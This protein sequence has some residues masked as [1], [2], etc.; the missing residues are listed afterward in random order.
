MAV[1]R[2]YVLPR[3]GPN[4]SPV[5][6]ELIDD[7]STKKMFEELADLVRGVLDVFTNNGG[8]KITSASELSLFLDSLVAYFK[9]LAFIEPILPEASSAVKILPVSLQALYLY[10]SRHELLNKAGV[11]PY[12]KEGLNRLEEVFKYAG[13]IAKLYSNEKRKEFYDVIRFPADTRPGPNTSSLLIHSL[14]TSAL[15]ST[16]YINKNGV[17]E[18]LP[19]VRLAAIF[20]DIGKLLDWRRHEKISSREM[21]ELFAIYVDGYAKKAVSEASQLISNASHPL[22]RFL[23]YGDRNS[24]ELDRVVALFF[25][26]IKDSNSYNDF[27]NR[28]K[29]YAKVGPEEA[30][31]DWNFWNNYVKE[32]LMEKLTEEFCKRVSTID[33]ENPAFAEEGRIV[34]EDV[35]FVRIDVRRIQ[36]FIKVNDIW[37]MN[38]ASRLIDL[39]L[40][41]G[42][43]AYLTDVLALPIENV[44][45]FGGGNETVV[46][47]R[48][49][50][51]EN[52][53][54][55][56][57]FVEHFNREFFE[58]SPSEIVF[59]TSPFYSV[60]RLINSEID[61]ELTAKKIGYDGRHQDVNPNIYEMCDF[62]GKAPAALMSDKGERVCILCDEKRRLGDAQHFRVRS[63]FL[64]LDWSVL[65]K[66]IIEYIAGHPAEGPRPGEEYLDLSLIRFD[67]ILTGQLM[68]SS[69]SLTDACERS[70]R[71]DL[72]IKEGIHEF[73]R[74][75]LDLDEREDL[76]RM[77]FGLMYAGGDDGVILLPSRLSIPFVLSLMNE[78]YLNMGCKSALSVGVIAAKPKHPLIHLYEACDSLLNIAK[79]ARKDCYE[80]LYRTSP[81]TPSDAFRG[82]LAFL[83]ADGG[84]ATNES[85]RSIVEEAWG[86]G[87]SRMRDSYYLSSVGD[88]KSILRLLNVI[89]YDR[90]IDINDIGLER[91]LEIVGEG[92]GAGEKEKK[93][94]RLKEV[95]NAI[96]DIF[97]S[98][99]FKVEP[100]KMEFIYTFKES[101]AA[102]SA[103]KRELMKEIASQVFQKINRGMNFNLYDLFLLVKLLGGGRV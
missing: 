67:G 96:Y 24:S 55:I 13:E 43:P 91:L 89:E 98:S 102:S 33:K 39:I 14:T 46:F 57:Q 38:G 41:V 5:Y 30:F 59:G 66:R 83:T 40:Y 62:C 70:S 77:V 90:K 86:E 53:E 22:R 17:D 93:V 101:I 64:G 88:E 76:N 44:L 18:N 45:Y 34:D 8:K 25:K 12:K 2:G 35:I 6:A 52:K 68:S 16:H 65:S 28:L 58:G 56:R 74:K 50:V 3:R 60:F 37:A 87:V 23:D 36:Q 61:R 82:S 21:E 81:L 94:S 103:A 99:K 71:I 10:L 20:H 80:E 4:D 95:R 78:Y 27:E 92:K 63:S 100:G 19:I 84:W 9:S 32:D 73:M 49:L 48:R 79:R 97:A 51:G 7:E 11:R 1:I 69:I 26:V 47:P 42:V 72:S 54:R 85:V 31:N 15:A 75:L 29:E